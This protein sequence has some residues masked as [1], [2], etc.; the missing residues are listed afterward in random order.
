MSLEKDIAEIKAALA[1]I[2]LALGDWSRGVKAPQTTLPQ[3]A[4]SLDFRGPTG[5]VK[6]LISEGYF[7][8]QRQFAD[9]MSQL[10][11]DG[12]LYRKQSFHNALTDMSK[13]GGPLVAIKQG[14]KKVYAERK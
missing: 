14:T 6:K 7:K 10:H 8:Q 9:I 3:K 5:G 12:Y 13:T 1:R 11:K 2:E 4:S